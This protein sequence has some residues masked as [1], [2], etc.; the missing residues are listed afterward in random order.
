MRTTDWDGVAKARPASNVQ[1][2][3]SAVSAFLGGTLE[4]YDFLLYASAAAII[5][6]RVFFPEASA[7]SLLSFATFGV[8]YLARPLGG[9]IIGHIGDRFGRKKA[10]MITLISMGIA[11]FL[12]GCLPTYEQVGMLAPIMLVGLRLIQGFSAGGETA[13]AGSLTMEHAPEG[14]RGFYGSFTVQGAGAGYVLASLVF[15]PIAAMPDEILFSWGWRLPFLASFAVL[16]LSIWMRRRIQEPEVFVEA[17]QQGETRKVPVVAAFRTNWRG[18]LRVSAATMHFFADTLIAV[19]GVA[20]AISMGMDRTTALWSTVVAQSLGLLVRPY[21]G[22]LS[23]RFGR[24]P[25][26]A[27]GTITVGVL[28]FF[29]L[30]AIAQGSVPGLFIFQALLSGVG[31]AVCGAVYPTFFAEQFKAP[32]RYTGMAVG[33]TLGAMVAG[34]IPTVAQSFMV[35][36]SGNWMPAA[37]IVAVALLIATIAVLTA[38]ETAHTPL[39]DLGFTLTEIA[40]RDHMAASRTEPRGPNVASQERDVSTR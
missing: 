18:V 16:F 19:F 28:T 9:L 33:M 35:A 5:F 23:D 38:K 32:V 34:F 21:A 36:D 4:Y 40:E 1:A 27:F 14:R 15:I 31:M 11:T 29:Y 2:K 24:K 39:Q 12:I 37:I 10:L 8:A 26:F 22:H 20:F 7:A 3:R 25:V 6:P 13:G 30:G 17:R